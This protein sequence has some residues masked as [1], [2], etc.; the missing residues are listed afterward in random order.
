MNLSEKQPDRNALNK[1]ILELR[2]L[3]HYTELTLPDSYFK[4]LLFAFLLFKSENVF[5]QMQ[6]NDL[7]NSFR[8]DGYTVG[9]RLLFIA[10]DKLKV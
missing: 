8:C 2:G 1:V 10:R 6:R 4:E 7:F 3:N 9:S 5:I